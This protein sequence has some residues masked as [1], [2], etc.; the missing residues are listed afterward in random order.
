MF[1]LILPNFFA[2]EN[3]GIE[4]KELLKLIEWPYI[5]IFVL[6][7]SVVKK[8]FG[9]LLQKATKFEWQ[10]VYTVLVMAT[11]L[12]VPWILLTDAG[13]MEIL[14]SYT[15]GTSFYEVILER[16]IGLFNNKT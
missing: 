2:M 9:D 15:I 13:W 10:P 6:L 3:L 1:N 16:V 8:G 5:I 4:F 11:I 7:A 14:V 12:A